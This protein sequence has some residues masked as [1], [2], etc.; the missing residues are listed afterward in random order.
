MKRVQARR[1]QAL[2]EIE[3]E[4]TRL[5]GEVTNLRTFEREYRSRLKSYF[6]EQLAALESSPEAGAAGATGEAS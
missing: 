2:G 1:R 3:Q 6:T 4:K 5:D